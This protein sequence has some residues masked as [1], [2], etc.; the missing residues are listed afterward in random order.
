MITILRVLCFAH[1][2]G[3]KIL[4]I[5]IPHAHKH[6]NARAERA[7]THAPTGTLRPSPHSIPGFF[8][9]AEPRD[10]EG[11]ALPPSID[12]HPFPTSP[13]PTSPFPLPPSPSP[14]S[15]TFLLHSAPP[16][17]LPPSLLPSLSPHI[18]SLALPCAHG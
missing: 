12:P 17:P 5:C 15:P 13:F 9:S 10:L 16:H 14:T 1:S 2:T 18:H 6:A 4:R 3:V 8:K 7:H 11:P